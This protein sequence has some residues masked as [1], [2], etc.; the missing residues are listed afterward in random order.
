MLANSDYLVAV[1]GYGVKANH[2][3]GV[4]RGNLLL[5][6]SGATLILDWRY[7]AVS[8]VVPSPFECPKLFDRDRARWSELFEAFR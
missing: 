3:W 1:K 4:G 5:C 8:F 6:G 2:L 7:R